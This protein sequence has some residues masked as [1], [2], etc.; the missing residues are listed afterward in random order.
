MALNKRL[1][2][3]QL[4][5][6]KLGYNN[7]ASLYTQIRK[8]PD[9]MYIG[10]LSQQDTDA[11]TAKVLYN[12]F[13]RDNVFSY[14]YESP[15]VYR[16]YCNLFKPGYTE[17]ETNKA[18]G[19]DPFIAKVTC[20]VY[21]GY[22]EIVTI[23]TGV[24]ADYVLTD[25]PVKI[26]VW[27]DSNVSTYIHTDCYD[28]TYVN[29]GYAYYVTEIVI[30]GN[31]ISIPFGVVPE[32]DVN[33]FTA[34]L[35]SIGYNIQEIIWGGL[36]PPSYDPYVQF[37]DSAYTLTSFTLDD[38]GGNTLVVPLTISACFPDQGC[39]KTSLFDLSLYDNPVLTEISI[40]GITYPCSINAFPQYSFI[41][42][43]QAFI[44][45]VIPDILNAP[46]VNFG[47]IE[48]G[49][50][51]VIISYVDAPNVIDSVTF[52]DDTLASKVIPMTSGCTPIA[53]LPQPY[54][55]KMQFMNDTELL[56]DYFDPSTA[57]LADWNNILGSS[58]TELR[59]VW[60][61]NSFSNC[62]EVELW[63]GS[64]SY[65]NPLNDAVFN[66]V[67]QG[68]TTLLTISDQGSYFTE[69]APMAFMGNIGLKN[70]VFAVQKIGESAFENVAIGTYN[71]GY[72]FYM[73][74]LNPTVTSIIGKKAFKNT[75]Y[76]G[77]GSLVMTFNGSGTSMIISE[78]AF[79]NSD[80]NVI[81]IDYII[82]IG[83]NAF[84]GCTT[85]TSLLLNM[86]NTLSLGTTSGDDGVFTGITGLSAAIQVNS[87]LQ[88]N[89]GGSPDG[90]LQTLTT[91]NP[92]ITI[93]YV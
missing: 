59:T 23:D 48:P 42:T 7:G 90:D 14:T 64:S 65:L 81:N 3:P 45:G 63:G 49:K 88:T 38:G 5:F 60:A 80:V 74:Q 61:Y 22:V 11:P 9:Y 67:F 69:I 33:S 39:F 57:V 25:T 78:E 92:G 91:N 70:V 85:L 37:K 31:T 29:I 35:Q 86:S 36:F 56:A 55:L 77:G 93:F 47:Q 15:G 71:G 26:M 50:F 83:N 30:D 82:S 75:S 87:I 27:S 44:A 53:N 10:F 4:L 54:T 68:Y 89:N 21:D 58:F 24:M 17:V 2:N 1:K 79:Y 66:T 73:P 34:Y 76:S 13:I 32:Y 20:T 40:N 41:P 51:K 16:I 43:L 18:Q 72:T 19:N 12:D 28:G 62:Y 46:N 84:N 52:T 8:S 6:E